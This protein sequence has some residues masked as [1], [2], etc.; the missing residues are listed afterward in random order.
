[1]D[2]KPPRDGYGEAILELCKDKDN[3]IILDTDVAKSTRTV[4]VKDK[5]PEWF[6]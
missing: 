3:V 6:I 1:M 4:W 2:K 5:Y